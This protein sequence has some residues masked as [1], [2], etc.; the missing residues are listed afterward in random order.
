MSQQ[1]FHIAI[2]DDGVYAS[3]ESYS[4]LI[5]SIKINNKR[6]SVEKQVENLI[7]HGSVC[8]EIISKYN[9]N[10]VFTSIKILDRKKRGSIYDLECAIDWCIKQ[11]IRLL[12]ISL[13]SVSECDHEIAKRI[14]RK[15]YLNNLI[16]IAAQSNSKKYT[17]LASMENIIGIRHS[18][19]LPVGKYEF[20]W[21]PYDGIDILTSSKHTIVYNHKE[22]T[23]SASNSFATPYITA[24]VAYIMQSKPNIKF[25]NILQELAIGST[26]CKGHYRPEYKS[27]NHFYKCKK[28]KVIKKNGKIQGIANKEIYWNY[29]V[30]NDIMTD[31]LPLICNPPKA[32]IVVFYNKRN[33]FKLIQLVK[34]YIVAKLKRD[35]IVIT[36]SLEGLIY[37]YE[38]IP[39]NMIIQLF[40]NA[41]LFKF[42]NPIIFICISKESQYTNSLLFDNMYFV[43]RFSLK[44]I[45]NIKEFLNEF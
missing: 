45:K 25:E 36:D 5:N 29:T 15:I 14:A 1:K 24:I 31:S 41:V 7:S 28:A 10:V 44:N 22:I 19:C 4:P 33:T 2:V 8:A 42:N 21:Y 43:N 3:E 18:D 13:G 34:K 16:V 35:V 40:L 37:G 11:R 6:I 27:V 23:L 17:Y 12:N 20:R 9:P 30:Y 38:I 26:I 32:K 39:N